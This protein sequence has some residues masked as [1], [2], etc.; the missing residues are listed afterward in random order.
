MNPLQQMPETIPVSMRRLVQNLF[1][2]RDDVIELRPLHRKLRP[3]LRDQLL[4]AIRV[5]SLGSELRSP[6][7]SCNQ[8]SRFVRI[9]PGERLLP[10]EHLIQNH[11]KREHVHLGVI[12]LAQKNLRGHVAVA[13]RLARELIHIVHVRHPDQLAQSEVAYLELVALVDDEVPRLQVPVDDDVRPAVQ[14]RHPA[15]YVQGECDGEVGRQRAFL[16]QRVQIAPGQILGDQHERLLGNSRGEELDNVRVAQL[17]QQLHLVD[18]ILHDF[19]VLAS[20]LT[21]I[22]IERGKRMQSKDASLGFQE[23]NL[24]WTETGESSSRRRSSR[25]R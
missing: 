3:A 5:I 1:E 19:P 6:T 8:V 21:L 23:R 18:K 13:P 7:L 4:H 24:P 25:A 22:K 20:T 2:L 12:I 16:N 17:H 9:L 10:F 14:V 15:S 11:P